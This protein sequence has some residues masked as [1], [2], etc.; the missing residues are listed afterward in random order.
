MNNERS[1]TNAFVKL[2]TFLTEF[3]EYAKKNKVNLPDERFDR[4]D[5][6]V[7]MAGH[8]NGWFDKE[9]VL[10][11]LQRWGDLLTTENLETWISIYDLNENLKKSVAIIMA[12]QHPTCGF[13]RLPM[14]SDYRKQGHCQTF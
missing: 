9:N 11:A 2:G 10:F 4:M 12:G 8:K 5:Q 14:R 1:R 3:C 13:S 6:A 7:R